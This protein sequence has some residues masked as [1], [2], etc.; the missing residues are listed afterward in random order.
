M[1]VRVPLGAPFKR[2]LVPQLS[3]SL[4]HLALTSQS[5]PI[6]GIN[7]YLGLAKFQ[8]GSIMSFTIKKII[9]ITF[10]VLIVILCVA[11]AALDNIQTDL[12]H[13]SPP[14]TNI[15]GIQYIKDKRTDLCFAYMNHGGT[16]FALAS[17]PCNKVEK[18]IK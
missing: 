2:S 9:L 14:K 10:L 16:G 15:Y 11:L 13:I 17:V 12:K 8:K 4:V 18:L 5:T 3:E 1:R 6:R 7:E